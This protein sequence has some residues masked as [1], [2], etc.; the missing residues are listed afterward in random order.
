M[1]ILKPVWKQLQKAE[2]TPA[3]QEKLG[4]L[5]AK[6]PEFGRAAK[7][8]LPG[9]V[10]SSLHGG[11]PDKI[12]AMLRSMPGLSAAAAAAKLPPP[13]PA[14]TDTASWHRRRAPDAAAI[15]PPQPSPPSPITT[16]CCH[17]P[18]MVQFV[19]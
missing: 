13:L 11:N 12:V 9:E 14:A 6:N 5:A 18:P 2:L 8:M 17:F 15:L 19:P 16:L 10:A 4:V 1:G 3:Q 7:F